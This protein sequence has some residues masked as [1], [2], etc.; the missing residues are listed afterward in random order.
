[1]YQSVAYVTRSR[2]CWS[3]LKRA[4]ARV[5]ASIPRLKPWP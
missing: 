5:D 4:A 3:S 1:M 2:S